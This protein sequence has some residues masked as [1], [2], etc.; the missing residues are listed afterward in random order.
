MT[1]SN[2]YFPLGLPA[3]IAVRFDGILD[4]LHP[5]VRAELNCNPSLDALIEQTKEDL[6]AWEENALCDTDP[7]NQAFAAERIIYNLSMI[8]ILKREQNAV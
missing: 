3:D 6:E 5:D 7:E 1:T 8:V 2:Q 4:H